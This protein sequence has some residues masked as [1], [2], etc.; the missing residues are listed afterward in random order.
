[1]INPDDGAVFPNNVIATVL[2]V[3]GAIDADVQS[4]A[5]PLRSTDP[6]LSIGVF[7]AIWQPDEES[8]EIGH[9]AGEPTLGT[10]QVGVQTLVKDGDSQRALNI[11][12]IF[13][14]RVRMVLYRNQP[15][16]DILGSLWTEDSSGAKE[17]MRRWGVRNQRYMSNDLQGSFIFTSVL[18]LYIETETI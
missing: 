13:Q 18:D 9:M 16:R 5:R 15:L 11:S 14:N 4:F 7:P 2:P 12:S 3:L 17:R 6:N 1:M 8:L 10:Y